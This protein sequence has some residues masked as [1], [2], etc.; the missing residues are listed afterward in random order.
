MSDV[1]A[2]LAQW[3]LYT[4]LAV[5]EGLQSDLCACLDLSP[6]CTN[7]GMECESQLST[8]TFTSCLLQRI[9]RYKDDST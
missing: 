5:G 7:D 9:G 3:F 8:T 6:A 2:V 1:G 4:A